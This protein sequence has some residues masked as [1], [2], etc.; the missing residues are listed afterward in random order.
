MT[1]GIHKVKCISTVN[2][3]KPFYPLALHLAT[4]LTDGAR[5]CPVQDGFAL[6]QGPAP[7]VHHQR[8]CSV[9]TPQHSARTHTHTTHH[10]PRVVATLG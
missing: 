3:I 10:T 6:Q 4:P 2:N 1:D 9:D 7:V 8:T 5:H